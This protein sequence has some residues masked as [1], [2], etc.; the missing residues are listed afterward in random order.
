MKSKDLI[1]QELMND[2]KVAMAS[3][4]SNAIVQVLTNFADSI[5]QNVLEDVRAYQ[6]TQD[7]EILQKR[8]IHQ[9]TQKENDF[10]QSWIDA[11]KSSNPKQVITDLDIALPFTVIDNVMEDLKVNHPLL[12]LIDFQNMTAVK[13]MLFNKQGK[14]L[15]VWGEIS[16]AITKE[17][18]GAIG[19]VDISLNKLSAFMPVS[20]DML[21]VGPQ[22]LDAY[23]R[24]ILSEA[25]AYGLEEGII[26]GTGHNQPIGM[27]RD[28]HE[29][30]SISSSDGYPAKTKKVITDLSDTTLGGL[31]AELAKDP[32]DST[33]ARVV[34]ANDIIFLVNPFDYYKKVLPSQLANKKM[35]AIAG[36]NDNPFDI[37]NTIQSDQMAEGTAILGLASKYK[38]GLGS[39]SAKGGKIEYSDEY[40]F[41]EDQ[42]YY[43]VK[44]HGN[45]RAT[46]DNDFIYLDING[47]KPINFTVNVAND[48][49]VAEIKGTVKTKEQA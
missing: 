38:M 25:I 17:L 14:Q 13:K 28:I 27:I 46:S 34:N 10:Y 45:G 40:K 16:S 21:Q 49:T 3:E 26:N 8:G 7:K 24:A 41:L 37:K 42:R 32:N 9:L 15:A 43:L 31:F 5:Q 47:L 23:V 29:G 18:S 48:V 44:L 1:K 2:M 33:K 6:N 30:V 12:N 35:N 11:A 20:K 4:D 19:Q 22:W 36:I 39:E